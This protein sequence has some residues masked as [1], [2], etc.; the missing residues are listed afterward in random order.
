MFSYLNKFIKRGCLL[1]YYLVAYHL[2]SSSL[3]VVGK[4]SKWFRVF[5][6]KFLLRKMGLCCNIQRG[7]YL[8]TGSDISMGNYSALGE[9]LKIHNTYLCIGDYVMMGP[10][11]MI[12]GGGHI[13]EK[14]DIP[15][16]R[17]GNIGKS[18]LIICDDVWIGTRV[19]ILGNV[20]TIGKGAIIVAGAVVTKPVPDYAIV[21]GNPAKVIKYRRI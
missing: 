16:A 5:L 17:Q 14:T 1:F 19:T 20:K 7:V 8:G 6:C 3:S 13:F 11:I 4:F 2:P 18:E 10:D 12:M 21:G 9:N 15:M